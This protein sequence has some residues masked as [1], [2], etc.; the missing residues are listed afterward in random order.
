MFVSLRI[1]LG[2]VFSAAM[3]ICGLLTSLRTFE[4]VDRVNEK[5]PKEEQFKPLGW[6]LSKQ[7]NLWRCYKS[8]YP[9]GALLLQVHV[10]TAFGVVFLLI[11][12]WS[13]SFFAR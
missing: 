7:Q 5:L 10:L 6:H 9:N 13:F 1:M 8:F 12:A 4:M 11:A 2:M 3:A